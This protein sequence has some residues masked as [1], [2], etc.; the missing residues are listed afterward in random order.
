[1]TGKWHSRFLKLSDMLYWNQITLPVCSWRKEYYGVKIKYTHSTIMA[2]MRLK[3]ALNLFSPSCEFILYQS[4]WNADIGVYMGYWVKMY[5]QPRCNP[6]KMY[7]YTEV[8]NHC[9]H[10]CLRQG[11][12]LSVRIYFHRCVFLFSPYLEKQ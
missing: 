9:L 5:A 10:H 11:F 12:C 3:H 6:I 1:M 4:I 2:S 8:S 7:F